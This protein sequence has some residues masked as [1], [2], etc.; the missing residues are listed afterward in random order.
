MEGLAQSSRST[1]GG[2]YG[3]Y[4]PEP[5]TQT[6]ETLQAPT[7]PA[8][9]G[10]ATGSSAAPPAGGTSSFGPALFHPSLRRGFHAPDLLPLLCPAARG[11]IDHG[12]PYRSEL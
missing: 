4:S 3:H 8:T 5:T 6:I 9:P 11:G 2:S 7:P 12:Q 1:Q 10:A